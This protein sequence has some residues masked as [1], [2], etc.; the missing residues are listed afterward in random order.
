MKNPK[1]QLI[2][3]ILTKLAPKLVELLI[4]ILEESINYDLD[5]DNK[6]GR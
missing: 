1:Q 2:A 4:K 6:I 3:V 5:G